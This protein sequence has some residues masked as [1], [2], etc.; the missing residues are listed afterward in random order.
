MHGTN[1]VKNLMMQ[2]R[3]PSCAADAARYTMCILRQYCEGSMDAERRLCTL[4]CTILLLPSS[5]YTMCTLRMPSFRYTA[6][7]AGGCAAGNSR[8]RGTMQKA[9]RVIHGRLS[10]QF[11]AILSQ[12]VR[13]HV[14]TLTDVGHRHSIAPSSSRVGALEGSKPETMYTTRREA[15]TA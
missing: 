1:V 2:G 11:D 3:D 8:I 9:F 14:V 12:D 6:A 5:S 10:I 7:A 15:D 13:V 4:R